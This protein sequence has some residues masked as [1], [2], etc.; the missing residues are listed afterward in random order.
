LW[1][2]H[3]KHFGKDGDPILVWQAAT[4]EMNSSVPQSFINTHM[5]EDPARAQAEYLAQF[6]SDVEGFVPPEV[7]EACV[8]DFRE[9]SPMTGFDYSGFVDPSGGSDAAMTL[10]IGHKTT[11]SEKHIVID[12]I[13][14]VRPP[15]DPVAVVD[16]FAAIGS[17]TI[18]GTSR[19]NGSFCKAATIWKPSI[20]GI[21]KSSKITDPPAYAE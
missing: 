16:N 21:I 17:E 10:A 8:G 15:F 9:M 11:T 12:L 19:H 3:R 13:R 4:R 14:E 18:T 5:A 20:S 7:V 1:D 2:A 6:R